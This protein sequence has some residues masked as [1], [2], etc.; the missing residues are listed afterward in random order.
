MTDIAKEA[1]AHVKRLCVDIGP[2][3]IGS[4][5]NQAAADYI[6]SIFRNAGLD[7]ER[8]SFSCPSWDHRETILELAGRRLEATANWFSLPCDLTGTI[9]PVGTLDELAQADL[10]GH[11]ALLYG[12]LTQDELSNRA[13]TV[14]YPER[15]R[16]TNQL[17]DEKLPIAVIA[18]CPLLNSMRHVIKDPD[19]DIPSATVAPEIGLKLVRH[20]GQPVR[21]RIAAARS[22]GH[23][24]NVL[25]KKPG[26]RPERV[27]ICAHYDTVWDA[28]GAYDNASGVGVML[29][30]AQV[31][32]SRELPVGLEFY[33]A[34][35]EEFTGLGADAYIRQYGLKHIPFRWDRQVG[36]Y[37]EVWKPIL[38]AI[39]SDGVGLEVG[40]NSVTYIAASRPFTAMAEAIRKQKY[41][42]MVR[43]GPWPAS[44]HYTFYSHGV[45][46]IALGSVGGVMNIH[47]QPID[48]IQWI[49]PVQLAEVVSLVADVVNA[50][51]DRTSDWCRPKGA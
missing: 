42:G 27:V 47:H 51:Q 34:S 17:L 37:S 3:P 30:L 39:N 32:A 7:V 29:T 41:P 20:A 9:V 8:Q 31:L 28:P 48:T 35:A 13:S 22:K 11:V 18:V 19:M 44:D 43:V 36:E 4:P 10:T 26:T 14:Y 33:A 50:L 45:P 46:S 40:A 49:S 1:M 25:G 12:E 5:G 38:A 15:H 23:S 6:E 21:L 16:E 2:R 24:C